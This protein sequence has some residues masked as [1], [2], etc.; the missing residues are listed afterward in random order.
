MSDQNC[1][2]FYSIR[3]SIDTLSPDEGAA[4]RKLANCVKYDTILVGHFWCF[5]LFLGSSF[6]P[7]PAPL[8]IYQTGHDSQSLVNGKYRIE[9][10]S[11]MKIEQ[12]FLISKLACYTKMILRF[13][14]RE[15]CHMANLIVRIHQCVINE[16]MGP[17]RCTNKQI[18]V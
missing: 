7:P 13:F 1:V 12:K 16:W 4:L 2:I 11:K 18:D 6:R 14:H 5:S 3:N 15:E 17:D 8:L 9:Y 10:E